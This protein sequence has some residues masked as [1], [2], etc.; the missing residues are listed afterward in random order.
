MHPSI[1][2]KRV[3]MLAEESMFGMSD[4]GLCTECGQEQIHIEPDA[5][6]YHCESCD[7]MAVCGAEDLLLRMAP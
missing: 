6:N 1:T 7:A 2:L 4:Y 3:M 5:H